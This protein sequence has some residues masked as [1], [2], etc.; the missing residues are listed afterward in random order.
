MPGPKPQ[1]K[2][3]KANDFALYGHFIVWVSSIDGKRTFVQ[4]V[5]GIGKNA[6]TGKVASY[7]KV[8]PVLTSELVA[9]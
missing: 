2:D 6:E 9:I 1:P 7:G 5:K 8:F 4:R 3:L